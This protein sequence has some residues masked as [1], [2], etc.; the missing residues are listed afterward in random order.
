MTEK[1]A[2]SPLSKPCRMNYERDERLATETERAGQKKARCLCRKQ[3]SRAVC[4]LFAA[5]SR[6]LFR[7]LLTR[8]CHRI[9]GAYTAKE[10][11]IEDV[12]KQPRSKC[13]LRTLPQKKSFTMSSDL[14]DQREVHI[15]SDVSNFKL[16]PF[17]NLPLIFSTFRRRASGGRK[18][19][20]KGEGDTTNL[21]GRKDG[22]VGGR[23]RSSHLCTGCQAGGLRVL[24]LS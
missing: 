5:M 24:L 17:F 11:R 4:E 1:T 22:R 6:S 13:S 2:P 16:A 10:S 3:M 14:R 19:I 7:L 9:I 15:Q 20:F 8:H 18:C 12:R 21:L 23:Q